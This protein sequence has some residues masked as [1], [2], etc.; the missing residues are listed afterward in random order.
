[1]KKSFVATIVLAAFLS[2]FFM[3]NAALAD[4]AA[5]SSATCVS[6]NA[7]SLSAVVFSH[8][9]NDPSAFA[10]GKIQ[11]STQPGSNFTANMVA[12]TPSPVL[13]SGS[14][15]TLN[16]ASD[17]SIGQTYYWRVALVVN[18]RD[19]TSQPYGSFQP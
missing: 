13:Q 10:D 12:I 19:I 4:K 17:L 9:L 15:T 8:S 1:M 18:N 7:T 14:S 6:V 16:L 3:T 11:I 2:L 5:L